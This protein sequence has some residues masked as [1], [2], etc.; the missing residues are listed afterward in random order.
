MATWH[1]S[2]DTLDKNDPNPILG[3][4]YISVSHFTALVIYIY[5]ITFKAARCLFVKGILELAS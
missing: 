3:P 4:H 5:Y 1:H 2:D